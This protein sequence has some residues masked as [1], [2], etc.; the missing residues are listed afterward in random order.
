MAVE[1]QIEGGVVMSLGYTLTEAF[2]IDDNC[3]P[4]A[5]YGTLGLWRAH[6]IP[7]IESIIVE[8]EGFEPVSYT[9]LVMVR[10]R[11]HACTDITGFG[12]L[13]HTYEMAQGSDVQITLQVDRITFMPQALDLARM[14]ILPCLL[15][16]SRCV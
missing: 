12:M 3:R 13:G 11:V 2:P 16:T 14:G 8:R 4:T 10:Y 9:H 7:E 5:K 6:Q 15:Y 1:G